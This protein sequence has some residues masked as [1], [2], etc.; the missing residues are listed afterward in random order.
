MSPKPVPA[1]ASLKPD[2]LPACKTSSLHPDAWYPDQ[3]DAATAQAAKT[4]CI[5][6]PVRIACGTGAIARRERYGIFAGFNIEDE[7]EEL[8]KFLA[9][10][11]ERPGYC[12]GCGRRISSGR[13]PRRFCW[14]CVRGLK[15]AGP[16]QAHLARLRAGGLSWRKI[17]A[18]ANVNRETVR[19][20]AKNKTVSAA[21]EDALMA[22]PVPAFAFADPLSKQSAG[23]KAS[24]DRR[25]VRCK[26]PMRNRNDLSWTGAF[27]G[28]QEHCE[29]CY[30]SLRRA[31]E[32]GAVCPA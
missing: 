17:A 31:R 2:D 22:V 23:D 10:G 26:A 9:A 12:T 20:V 25:C 24:T 19:G 4:V 11:D 6:C 21:V 3:K 15:D 8:E 27:H 29:R 30:T 13:I 7:R 32:R 18:A 5:D 28:G 14:P 1:V 16:V